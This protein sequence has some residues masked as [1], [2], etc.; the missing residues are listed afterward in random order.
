MSGNTLAALTG[1]F[2]PITKRLRG[3]LQLDG[4]E[5]IGVPYVLAQSAVPTILLSSATA[6]TATGAI[7]GL[8]ALPYTPSGVVQVFMD[9]S[10]IGG[11]KGLYYARFSSTTACQLYTDPAGS[12]QPSGITAGAYAGLTGEQVLASILLPAGSMGP[13]GSTRFDVH[14]TYANSANNKTVYI[15]ANGTSLAQTTLTTTA[16]IKKATRWVNR[17]AQNVNMSTLFGA[18]EGGLTSGGLNYTT[19]DT[20]QNVTFTLT[21]NLANAADYAMV[22]AYLIEVIPG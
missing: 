20:S 17:G 9:L 18:P 7:T 22:E 8:T 11:V 5:T 10:G 2:D 15:R 21:A 6:I 13:N 12:I 4:T 19:I 3:L 16:W 1:L 14:F